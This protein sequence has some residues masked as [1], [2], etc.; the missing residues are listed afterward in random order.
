[1]SDIDR[2]VDTRCL[3]L[4]WC[5]TREEVVEATELASW[6]T[7]LLNVGKHLASLHCLLLWIGGQLA[8]ELGKKVILESIQGLQACGIG[9]L[10]PC[11]KGGEEEIASDCWIA[12]SDALREHHRGQKQL[13]DYD[14]SARAQSCLLTFDVRGLPQ[15]G[16]LDGGVR[17]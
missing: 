8:P 9:F 6:W 1:L 2:G 12:R 4:L 3:N 14:G 17:P 13:Q 10:A 7:V 15:A 5:H 11:F 16:P